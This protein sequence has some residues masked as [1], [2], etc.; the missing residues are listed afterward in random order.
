MPW[1]EL[2]VT[3]GSDQQAAIEAALTDLG[4][5]SITLEDAE[6]APILEPAPGETP[7][8]PTIALSALFKPERGRTALIDAMVERVPELARSRLVCNEIADRDW[9]REWMDRFQ[10]MRF[11]RRLW[12]YPSTIEPPTDNDAVVVRLDPGLA[13]GTGTHATTALCLEWLDA[14]EPAGRSVID[15][16]CGSGVLAIAALKLGAA[17]ALGVDNDPQALIASRANAE[18]NNVDRRLALAAP[19]NVGSARCDVLV[20]NILAGPLCQLASRF[21]SLLKPGGLIA[22]SGILHGQE[23]EVI[24]S[25]SEWFDDVHIVA[26]EGWL[27]VEAVRCGSTKRNADP[28]L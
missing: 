12:I 20:A 17:H 10:P 6:D 27:R 5:L 14:I 8:W 13:F 23:D 18:L 2:C 24:E 19:D 25:C 1:L 26:H 7:L 28:L 16:G 9:T 21:A 11:G 15:Y 3:V 4:A 22:L